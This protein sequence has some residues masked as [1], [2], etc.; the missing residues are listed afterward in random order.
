MNRFLLTNISISETDWQAVISW[1]EP[2]GPAEGDEGEA[3]GAHG[4]DWEGPEGARDTAG[5]Q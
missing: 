5:G 3:D 2:P 4:Q 1:G